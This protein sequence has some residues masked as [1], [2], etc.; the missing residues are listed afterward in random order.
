MPGGSR[1][2]Q[3]YAMRQRLQQE[4]RWRGATHSVPEQEE[5]EPPAR[6]ARTDWYERTLSGLD[7]GAPLEQSPSPATPESLPPLEA[8]PTPEGRRCLLLATGLAFC[9]G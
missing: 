6:R 3:W 1:F 2:R 4:G 8:S 9:Y 7:V 5:G